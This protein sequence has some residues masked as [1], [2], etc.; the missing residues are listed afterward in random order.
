MK[1]MMNKHTRNPYLPSWEYIPDGEPHIFDGRVYLYGSH[2]RFRGYAYC[3]NDYVCWSAP[4]EDLGDWRYE[5]VIYRKTSDPANVD[6][7]MCLYAPDVVKGDDGR[8]YLYYVLDQLSVVSVAVCDTPA[9]EY[10]FLDYVH[11]EDG[12]RLGEGEED[13]PQFDP[14]VMMENHKVY[15]YTGFCRK[16]N[17]KCPGAM[18]TVLKDDMCTVC[19]KPVLVA[20]SASHCTGTG[21]E[22][23][24][25]FEAASI[26][27]CGDLYYFIYSSIVNYEL[28]Y[29]TS[30]SPVGKF[31]Y[32][33]VIVSN[34]DVGI[35][36]NKPIDKPMCYGGNN[37]GSII[38]ILGK[39]YVFYHR[40]TDGTN[41][42]RQGC[43]EPICIEE[44]GSIRQV[45]MTSCGASGQPF[46]GKGEYPAWIACN[47]L[48][49]TDCLT[50]GMPGEWMDSRF[51]KITQDG[52]D[53]D[54][55][56]GYVANLQ[57]G[58]MAGFKYFSCKDITKIS[59]R[60]RGRG[61]G[62]IEVL[63]AWNGDPIGEISISNSNEWKE[64]SADIAVPAGINAFYFRFVGVRSIS[65]LSFRL[66]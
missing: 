26:R 41:Y 33:G 6:G 56:P 8:Y 63:T 27:K 61:T 4:V 20:P 14:G 44:D 43:I 48:C 5:G 22:D 50:T 52:S 53:G 18:V 13:W 62:K 65:L 2:D 17:E 54:T 9:G 60:T 15:L 12:T 30:T 28:C 47:L 34:N 25:Y 24:A 19:E 57:N 55:T 21:Y 35:D 58:A 46:E 45:E 29:A 66:E 36:D 3:L 39:W 11:Y 7:E 32:R 49:N 40:H 51:P 10:R 16:K 23:H 64:H 1:I 42:S 31:T 59:V 38:E 37:H